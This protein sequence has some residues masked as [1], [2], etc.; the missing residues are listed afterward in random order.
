M[1]SYQNITEE[2][3]NAGFRITSARLNTGSQSVNEVVTHIPDAD[4]FH[5]GCI[6]T[7][8]MSELNEAAS[9]SPGLFLLISDIPGTD[10]HSLPENHLI[11]TADTE[12]SSLYAFVKSRLIR[13][14]RIDEATLKLSQCLLSSGSIQELLTIG[15]EELENPI[16]LSDNSTKILFWSDLAKF[17][18]IDDE[19]VKVVTTYGY[20][21]SEYYE[22]YN[23]ETYLPYIAQS[24]HAFISRSPRPEKKDRIIS[25]L[26][27]NGVYFG[28]LVAVKCGKDFDELD[29]ALMDV[30]TRII[31][32]ELEKQRTSLPYGL[33]E[34]LLMELMSGQISDSAE[35]WNR[36]KCFSWTKKTD[37][38]VVVL[39]FAEKKP[40]TLEERVALSM[41][42]H[43]A[44]I[45]PGNNI[46]SLRNKLCMLLETGVID[47]TVSQLR[48]FISYY[49][50]NAAISEC[51]HDILEF[52]RCFESS[53]AL[54]SFGP[55]ISPGRSIFVFEELALYYLISQI[56]EPEYSRE[57]C[58]PGLYRLIE[59]DRAHNT[60]YVDTLR[61]FLR[62]RSVLDSAAELHIHRNTMNY[63]LQKIEDITGCE[64]Y[65]GDD[66]YKLWLTLMMDDLS[67]IK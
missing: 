49:G 54:L 41:K 36:A 23:Y 43:L 10:V 52:R 26:T 7:A 55:I 64:L 40:Y 30:L 31:V 21:T 20:V 67:T 53:L 66:I 32:M 56:S 11:L 42:K 5:R 3:N 14:Q 18:E 24:D 9:G 50:L 1:L 37:Y 57:D 65:S 4:Q 8:Y 39:D 63:R 35:F 45:F 22:K 48:P 29:C 59:Y 19:L 27:V 6:L 34:N 60:D 33:Q 12:L 15:E 16:F 17:K 13:S 2:L 61:C 38:R 25:K 51:F 44:I 62:N 58:C 46:I 28:W 47:T